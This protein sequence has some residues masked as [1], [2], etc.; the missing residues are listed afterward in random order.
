[1]K[2][3]LDENMPHEVR[4]LLPGHE[5][6][7]VAFKGWRGVRNGNLLARAAAEGFDVVVTLD[8]SMPAQ[9]NVE[10][11]PIGIIVLR[12]QKSS[13]RHIEALVDR[14]RI[15]LDGFVRRSV[16]VIRP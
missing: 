16:V 2:V 13:K 14:L 7:T 5:V 8:A 9:Q 3:L 4:H 1:M 12:P 11:L 6:F 15:E 10:A